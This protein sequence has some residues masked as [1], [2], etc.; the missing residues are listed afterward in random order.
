MRLY[1]AIEEVSKFYV[2]GAVA[3]F[4]KLNPN[5]W[6]RVCDE[7]EE[8]VAA[9]IKRQDLTQEAAHCRV[10]VNRLRGLCD[11]FKKLG[12]VPADMT[13]QDAYYLAD[14]SRA[15]RWQSVKDKRCVVCD[16]KGKLV[17][18]KSAENPEEVEL[19][20]GTCKDKPRPNNKDRNDE[21]IAR[22]IGA[23]P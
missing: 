2:V 12:Q 14:E 11:Q 9:A 21:Y 4:D 5:P 22:L 1:Q 7:F 16:I 23:E 15:R 17:I 19:V 3:F 18:R 10:Y 13:D 8:G 20:C 6:Q